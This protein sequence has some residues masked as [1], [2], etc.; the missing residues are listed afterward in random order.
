MP[1]LRGNHFDLYLDR[2]RVNKSG[3]ETWGNAING[4]TPGPVLNWREGD[5]VTLNVT[6]NMPEMTG[7]HWHGIILP[8]PIDGVLRIYASPRSEPDQPWASLEDLAALAEWNEDARKRRWSEIHHQLPELAHEMP[9]G[10][11]LIAQSMVG[12]LFMAWL[13]LGCEP[14]QALLDEWEKAWT[15][16][17]AAQFAHLP[18]P[19][20]LAVMR[21]ANLR[22]VPI[23]P[24]VTK[25]N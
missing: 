13:Q 25:V 2:V 12:G 23:V 10:T 5:V 24:G 16:A 3:T 8:N 4:L 15:E 11:R 18:R 19:E 7:L 14:A 17:F 22:N 1:V 21:T 9:D 20:W 6:N